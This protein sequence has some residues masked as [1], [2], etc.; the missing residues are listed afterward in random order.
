[1]QHR[2]EQQ[3][4]H[5]RD[6]LRGVV[7][8]EVLADPI[9]LWLYATDGGIHAVRPLVVVRPRS[10]EDVSECARYASEHGISIHARGAG[11]GSAGESLGEG[12]ILDFSA[13]M[14]RIVETGQ[15]TVRVQPGIARERVDEHLRGLGRRFPSDA[16]TRPAT[17]VGGTLAVGGSGRR[18][19]A[20]GDI[21]ERCERVQV[22]LADGTPLDFGTEPLAGEENADAASPKRRIVRELASLLGE[23]ESTLARHRSKSPV[24]RAGYH[25]FD[26]LEEDRLNVARLLVASEGTLGLFTEMVVRTAPLPAHRACALLFFETAETAARAVPD[27]LAHRP[28]ACDLLESRY[29]SL[30]RETLGAFERLIPAGAGALLVVEFESDN[31]AELRERTRAMLARVGEKKKHRFESRTTFAPEEVDLAD[32]LVAG[33]RPTLYRLE[34][35][36]KPIPLVE[37]IAVPPAD[38]AAFLGVV[39]NTLK[40]R[41]VTALLSCHA[42]QGQV[43]LL[44]FVDLADPAARDAMW[45]LAN[46]LYEQVFLVGGTV[47]AEHATG[48]SRT[49]FLKRQYGELYPVLEQI[50]AIFDP[51]NLLNPGKI[52]ATADSREWLGTLIPPI[53]IESEG[54]A[55]AAIAEMSP[56]GRVE[57]AVRTVEAC[58]GCGA[59]RSRAMGTRVCPLLRVQPLEEASPRGKVNFIR[60]FLNGELPPELLLTDEG[61]RI[62]DLCVHCE[63]CR[64]ICPSRVDVSA[65]IA[66]AKAAHVAT[67]GLDPNDRAFVHAESLLQASRWLGPAAGLPLAS[68]QGRWIVEKTLGLSRARRLPRIA[69][70]TFLRRAARRGWT[71][72]ERL[73]GEKAALFVDTFVNQFDTAIAE[74]AVAVLRHNDIPFTVPPNQ[75]PSGVTAAACGAVEYTAAQARKN[76]VA[77]GDAVRHGYSIVVLEPAAAYCLK[78]VYPKLVD[79]DDARQV[80][81]RVFDLSEYLWRI[82]EQGRLEL[83]FKPL[84]LSVGYHAPCR[85]KAMEIGTPGASL[86]GLIPG[87]VVRTIEEGCCGAAGSFGLR[88]D[89]FRTSLR[90]GWQLVSR[91][92]AADIQLTATECTACRLQLAQGAAKESLHPVEILAKAYGLT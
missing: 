16:G 86:L 54:P 40:R 87:L 8:G 26:I 77:L 59:C 55:A 88:R 25:V 32:E 19:L 60:G 28:G 45:G 15:D 90:A 91:M 92:R 39:Q 43:H 44:P 83:D 20:F 1:M 27:V 41:Q 57:E 42:G 33:L 2:W 65:L 17:T 58:S 24:D 73:P 84:N 63:M 81:E 72:M 71:K 49:P 70:K 47:S 48:L 61:K 62:L 23:H 35:K 78:Y 12:I 66:G 9:T 3:R 38:L 46:E 80:A 4:E 36:A 37:D 85:L 6:D 31:P 13:H 30:A 68:P 51:E 29:L 74:A 21:A 53:R 50:K 69:R 67:N 7:S 22:V 34:G 5:V 14:R 11:T 18:R 79:D 10:V 82:H 76:T 89:G 75:R 56:Y 52:I 64:L